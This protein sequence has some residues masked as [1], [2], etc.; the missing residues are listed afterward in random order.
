MRFESYDMDVKA[1]VANGDGLDVR[2]LVNIVVGLDPGTMVGT[3]VA[4]KLQIQGLQ[5][6]DGTKWLNIGDA[7]SAE[8]AP[9]AVEGAWAK[10]RIAT[11]EFN[12]GVPAAVLSAFNV[13]SA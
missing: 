6:I 13:R 7:V 11:T 8:A 10:L 2:Q 4:S 12:T 9:V 1:A 3:T 5:K